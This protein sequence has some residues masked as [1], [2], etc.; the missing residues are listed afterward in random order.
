[1]KN[2]LFIAVSAII[3]GGCSSG[4]DAPPYP[5]GELVSVNG[6]SLPIELI[7][8]IKKPAAVQAYK[9]PR[10]SSGFLLNTASGNNALSEEVARKVAAVSS[11]PGGVSSANKT[12]VVNTPAAEKTASVVTAKPAV[13]KDVWPVLRLGYGESPIIA[14]KRWALPR[15]YS[16]VIVDVSDDLSKRLNRKSE[17]GENFSDTFDIS[18]AK[19]SDS[20]AKENP[21]YRFYISKIA[22]EKTIVIHDKGIGRDA[23]IFTVHAG[24]LMD[25]AFRL[26][27][28]LGWNTNMDS[29]P[30]DMPNPDVTIPFNIIVFNDPLDAF[31]KLFS[32][33]Q[34]QAQLVQGTNDVYFV[35]ARNSR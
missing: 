32:R 24:S 13:K 27:E 33:Y 21:S 20:L 6:S 23:K 30:L 18:L 2:K 35:Q 26:S 31:K 17:K 34:I 12:G 19:M 28:V 10:A 11:I 16:S 14:I 1:M 22:D 9:P 4:A 7:E 29:W 5:E 8:Y 3:I 25:N 15:G